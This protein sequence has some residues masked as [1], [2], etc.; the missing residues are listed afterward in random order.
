MHAVLLA[1]ITCWIQIIP[2]F[3]TVARTA[4]SRVQVF[5][6]EQL[7]I[8]VGIIK[9]HV[10]NHTTEIFKLVQ[11]LWDNALLQLPLMSLVEA[12]GKALDAEFKPFIPM[13]L[14]PIL[15][16]FESELNEMTA[17]TQM[18][19]F[20]VEEYLQ[21]EVIP[22]VPDA[23]ID[24]NKTKEGAEI[25]FT[26]HFYEYVPP[27]SLEEIDRDLDEVLGRIRVRLEEVKG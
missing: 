12:L 7:A 1:H 16:V 11:D 2:A 9:Q 4:S 22:F 13:I 10:R 20:D 24:H 17:N 19:I 25:P 8:L 26:R 21:R 3:A 18:K 14:P 15:K 27:R 5:H 6:L 23:W